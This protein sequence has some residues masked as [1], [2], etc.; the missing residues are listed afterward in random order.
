[1]V[2]A[3]RMIFKNNDTYQASSSNESIK[4]VAVIAPPQTQ[5]REGGSKAKCK[6][7]KKVKKKREKKEK[8]RE[9]IGKEVRN[10]LN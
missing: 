3:R 2:S 9:I 4:P 7:R 8:E 1:M 5:R 10:V 6:E